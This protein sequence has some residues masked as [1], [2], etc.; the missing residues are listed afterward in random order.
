MD[1]VD[2]KFRLCL[3]NPDNGPI[4]IGISLSS[5][6]MCGGNFKITAP[7]KFVIDDFK[8]SADDT[9]SEHYIIHCN[10][11]DLNKAQL[12]WQLL[13]CSKAT[14]ISEGSIVFDFYQMGNRC[15]QNLESVWYFRNI[16]ACQL[17]NPASFQG[18][19][20]F[21]IKEKSPFE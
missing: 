6:L 13:Y 15:K 8:M 1:F 14:N 4:S 21:A 5:A 18:I 3:I 16:P 7:S 9:D 2:T 11:N 12:S 10:P 19:I 17:R 20:T